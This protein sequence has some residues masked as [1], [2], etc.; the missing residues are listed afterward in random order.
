MNKENILEVFRSYVGSIVN[1]MCEEDDCFARILEDCFE[2]NKIT[3]FFDSY[4]FPVGKVSNWPQT[5]CWEAYRDQ[6]MPFEQKVGIEEG[7]RTY[8]LFKEP[9][10]YTEEDVREM[11]PHLPYEA[12]K[13]IDW[14][15]IDLENFLI[16]E[17]W[18]NEDKSTLDIIV[19][20]GEDGFKPL[21]FTLRF[22]AENKTLT[23]LPGKEGSGKKE[24][25][26][27]FSELY[28]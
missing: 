6:I 26:E 19:L 4:N 18:V 11:F 3:F 2:G 25:L 7:E 21:T 14:E 27:D 5:V 16:L 15:D 28:M 8:F 22:D 9:K 20:C 10:E 23:A 17:T 1:T 12:F 24:T 13:E